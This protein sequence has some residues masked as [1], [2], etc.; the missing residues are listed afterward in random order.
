[1]T[2]ASLVPRTTSGWIVATVFA[3][4]VGLAVIDHWTHVLGVLPYLVILACPLMHVVM[5]R[6]H[7]GHAGH[8]RGRSTGS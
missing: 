1:M 6:G 8:G 5:H 7:G 4:G 2:P 3:I